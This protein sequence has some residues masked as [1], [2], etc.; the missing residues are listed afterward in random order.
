M[1]KESALLQRL[2]QEGGVVEICVKSTTLRDWQA[3]VDGLLASGYP[4]KFSVHGKPAALNLGADTF[5]KSFDSVY[6]LEV[7]VGAQVWTTDFVGVDLIDFQCSPHLIS[8]PTEIQHLSEFMRN[9][10]AS[11]RKLV[12][13]IPETVHPD[14]VKPYAQVDVQGV[15]TL[16]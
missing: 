14:H 13:F 7:A 6:S 15:F 12:E 8:D 1:D 3:A 2:G 10:A 16:R 5:G 9:I 11:V 4:M